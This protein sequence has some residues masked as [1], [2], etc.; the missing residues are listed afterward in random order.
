M[1]SDE[2]KTNIK[3]LTRF[4]LIVSKYSLIENEAPTLTF[5]QTSYPGFEAH[6]FTIADAT[7]WSP[8][9]G[10]ES[11]VT[12]TGPKDVITPQDSLTNLLEVTNEIMGSLKQYRQGLKHGIIPSTHWVYHETRW[13][14]ENWEGPLRELK[15]AKDFLYSIDESIRPHIK[16]LNDLGFL[17]TQSCS[18][19]AREHTDRDPYLPYVMFDERIFPRSGAHLFTLADIT[20]WIPS[21]GPHN[22]DIEFRLHT[23]EDSKRFWDGLVV[24]ARRL[25]E[26]LHEYREQFR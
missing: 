17:T 4:D 23:P 11:S 22:F 21:Y 13:Y 6:L 3:A 7:L 12:L 8:E 2:M 10:P 19:L 15:P 5:D 16:E 18:G 26:L 25:A 9:F 14:R 1:T 24:T 20:G